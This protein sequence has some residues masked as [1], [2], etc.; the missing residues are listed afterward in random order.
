MVPFQ[1]PQ[2]SCK[3]QCAQSN[4]GNNLYQY[5]LSP[6]SFQG[7]NGPDV[8]CPDVTCLDIYYYVNLPYGQAIYNVL[9][10]YL[11]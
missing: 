9:Y 5:F 3:L 10:L 1:V 2:Q 4:F 11:L 7:S 6:I 8:T